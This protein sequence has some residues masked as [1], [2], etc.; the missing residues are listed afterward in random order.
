MQKCGKYSESFQCGP[1]KNQI[2]IHIPICFEACF[3][4]VISSTIHQKDVPMLRAEIKSLLTNHTVE[5]VPAAD[6]DRLLQ[7]LFSSDKKIN[8]V[9]RWPYSISKTTETCSGEA[10]FQNN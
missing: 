7:L 8:T 6:R 4:G 3:S 9:G 1:S 10:A 5:I 2:Q